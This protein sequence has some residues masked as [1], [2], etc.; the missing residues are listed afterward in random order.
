[1]LGVVRRGTGPSPWVRACAP[2]VPHLLRGGY[3][4]GLQAFKGEQRHH[5]C[6]GAPEE[7]KGGG[8][9]QLPESQSWRRR[10]GTC[11]TQPRRMMGGI[12]VECSAFGHTVSEAKTEIMCLCTEGMSP[13]PYSA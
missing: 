6:F 4:R 3:K 12:V 11:F 5:G 2:P 13:P 9:E 1:M 10:F 7:E 8:G